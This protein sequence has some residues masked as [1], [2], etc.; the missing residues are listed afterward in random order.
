MPRLEPARG[1]PK[2]DPDPQVRVEILAAAL[3]I[4]REEGVRALGISQV[5]ARAQLGTRAFYRHFD[6][7]DQLVAAL[8]LEMAH[9]ERERLQRRMTG[10]DPIRAVAAWI[11]G[12]LDL[13]FDPRVQSDL[14]QLSV[15]AQS[16][17][18]AASELVA[19]A[20]SEM[21]RPLIEQ[22]DRG[23][24]LGLFADVDPAVEAL[25]I[26][27]VVW[28]NIERHWATGTCDRGDTRKRVQRFCLRG[29]GVAADVIAEIV[30]DKKPVGRN[31][32]S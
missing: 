20:Y 15:E 2:L 17:M 25:S 1:R 31:R 7:K 6:S 10:Q 3:A 8:F 30:A 22:I 12:R 28:A 5:L 27:G 21:L 19:P 13:A 29:L 9:V 11:D 26:Q 18:F 32:K 23:T 24:Q 14:R 16:Q 4:V